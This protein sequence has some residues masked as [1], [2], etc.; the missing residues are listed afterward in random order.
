MWKKSTALT[1]AVCRMLIALHSVLQAYVYNGVLSAIVQSYVESAVF[2]HE[3]CLWCDSRW[4]VIMYDANFNSR[5]P[6]SAG[7]AC[8]RWSLQVCRLEMNQQTKSLI[9]RHQ[10]KRCWLNEGNSSS[11]RYDSELY[12]LYAEPCL[13]ACAQ[14]ELMSSFPACSCHENGSAVAS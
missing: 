6:T 5:R 10:I 12:V 3:N 13:F 11:R 1:L 14:P 7:Q 8:S 2:A 9:L 4:K